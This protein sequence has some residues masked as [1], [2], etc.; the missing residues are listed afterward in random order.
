LVYLQ[1]TAVGMDDLTSTL[2]STV[3]KELNK[4]DTTFAV[5][6]VV[7]RDWKEVEA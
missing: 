2:F 4:R 6:Q 1:V 3:M 5:K 7:Q